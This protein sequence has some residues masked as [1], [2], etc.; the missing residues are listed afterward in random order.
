LE[1]NRGIKEA[2]GCI[3]KKI[4]MRLDELINILYTSAN[5]IVL[6]TPLYQSV[7]ATDWITIT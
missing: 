4:N 1:G 6:Y 7:N 3:P 2:K 5:H